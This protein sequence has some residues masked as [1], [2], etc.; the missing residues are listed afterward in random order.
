MRNILL[1]VLIPLLLV[2]IVAQ[3]DGANA[4]F[5]S[6]TRGFGI[7]LPD[8]VQMDGIY[9]FDSVVD[10]VF[11]FETDLW[12]LK[13]IAVS[14][15]R[16]RK[17]SGSVINTSDKAFLLQRT[18]G[19]ITR[20]GRDKLISDYPIRLGKFSGRQMVKYRPE[21]SAL[22]EILAH[23]FVGEREAFVVKA[24]YE[25]GYET[26]KIAFKTIATFRI[27]GEREQLTVDFDNTLPQ[28]PVVSRQSNDAKDQ[29]LRGTVKSI[30]K[31]TFDM[32]GGS[33]RIFDK[34][35]Y[36][37]VG[38]LERRIAYNDNLPLVVENFGYLKGSRVSTSVP[39]IKYAYKKVRG[40]EYVGSHVAKNG[41][42]R[43]EQ[44]F[45][46]SYDRQGRLVEINI[47]DNA[48]VWKSRK[49][50]VYN[51][52]TVTWNTYDYKSKPVLTEF[53][54]MD[55]GGNVI[56]ESLI[57][58]TNYIYKDFDKAGN[59]TIRVAKT[60]TS[61]TESLEQLEVRYI[62]YYK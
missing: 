25:P 2:S 19:E 27:I 24:V 8:S 3:S 33:A 61:V 46:Y 38:D 32:Q 42:P 34:S 41:D 23:V 55:N 7:I 6:P 52:R 1:L 40:T 35:Y 15:S 11:V 43:Y 56:E 13:K 18:K 21:I 12:K 60:K 51:D 57:T 39:L 49:T 50:A 26:N 9:S 54:M 16:I 17:T 10:G 29:G 4:W 30:S 62:T 31:M 14:V 20:R 58:Q 44:E 37:R 28:F 36:S 45:K 59:W 47:W 53:C 48:H 22:P 5:F